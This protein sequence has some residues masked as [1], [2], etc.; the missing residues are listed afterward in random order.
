MRKWCRG[1]GCFCCLHASGSSTSKWTTNK[2]D[3]LFSI[4]SNIHTIIII[5]LIIKGCLIS[6]RILLFSFLYVSANNTPWVA[7]FFRD[8]E[9]DIII[10]IIIMI[11]SFRFWYSIFVFSVSY[12]DLSPCGLRQPGPSRIRPKA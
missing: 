2:G 7:K 8:W 9:W 4:S 12:L 10:I 11:Y 5:I 3:P 1:H 6:K